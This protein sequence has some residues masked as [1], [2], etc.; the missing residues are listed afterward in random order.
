M[1]SPWRNSHSTSTHSTSLIP[2][3]SDPPCR[4]CGIFAVLCVGVGF[5][6]TFSSSAGLCSEEKSK[7]KSK[8]A[9]GPFD[10]SRATSEH[11]QDSKQKNADKK[12]QF[13]KEGKLEEGKLA[14]EI[15]GEDLDGK[16]FQLSDYAGKVILLDF[17]GHW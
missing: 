10:A 8:L 9:K 17:W 2:A 6:F 11:K 14:I 15:H 7:S 3:K 5:L 12:F 16:T 4:L 1:A 13:R